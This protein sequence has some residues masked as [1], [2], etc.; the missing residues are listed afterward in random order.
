MLYSFNHLSY[1]II[2][3]QKTHIHVI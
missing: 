2:V 3:Y 1:Y